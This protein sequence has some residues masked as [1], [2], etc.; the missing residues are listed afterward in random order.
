LD[1]YDLRKI[2][3]L[4]KKTFIEFKEVLAEYSLDFASKYIPYE[5]TVLKSLSL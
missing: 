3:N 1:S 5:I 2:R 4:G